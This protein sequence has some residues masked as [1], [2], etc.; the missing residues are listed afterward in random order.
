VTKSSASINVSRA[1]SSLPACSGEPAMGFAAIVFLSESAAC[2]ET[3]SQSGPTAAIS[4]LMRSPRKKPGATKLKRW[5]I[6]IMRARGQHIG[7]VEA[8]SREAAEASAVKTFNLTEEQRRR[9][10]ILERE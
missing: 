9:L 5:R 6:S 1:L 10:A 2:L 8:E 7:T 4:S 3:D